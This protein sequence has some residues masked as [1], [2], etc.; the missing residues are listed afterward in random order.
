ME[1]DAGTAG[2]NTAAAA[3]AVLKSHASGNPEVERAKTEAMEEL[4]KLRS[5]EPKEARMTEFRALL[6]KWHPD[7]NPDRVELATA[8]FQFLQK[9]KPILSAE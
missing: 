3:A 5:V 2:S 6:R 4:M 1:G 8:V 7:K 9:G